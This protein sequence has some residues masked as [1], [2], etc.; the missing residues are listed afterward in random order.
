[1]NDL[2]IM[3]KNFGDRLFKDI[4]KSLWKSVQYDLKSLGLNDQEE[5][6]ANDILKRY[7]N[8][9]HIGQQNKK[10]EIS[11]QELSKELA[12]YCDTDDLKDFYHF[13]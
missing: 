12:K 8:F 1:M 3:N 4:V 11:F 5:K 10:P 13:D 7:L 9:F 6:E 2:Q